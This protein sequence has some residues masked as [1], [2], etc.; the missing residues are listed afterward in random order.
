MPTA[1]F[2]QVLGRGPLDG[3]E[4]VL[5]FLLIGTELALGGVAATHVLHHHG[6]AA[7]QR[8]RKGG[9]A[10]GVPVPCRTGCGTP[11]WGTARG[12]LAA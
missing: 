10:P 9:C 8:A 5:A 1:P 7:F 3:V 4:A 2:D 11:A 6:V 12:P